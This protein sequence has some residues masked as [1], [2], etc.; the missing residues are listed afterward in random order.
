MIDEG[1]R[2][3][4][5]KKQQMFASSRCCFDVHLGS[6]SS[7]MQLLN[8]DEHEV[9]MR[10]PPCKQPYIANKLTHLAMWIPVSRWIEEMM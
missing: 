8:D 7:E 6:F 2:R 1:Q 5:L 4:F 10:Y 3:L 9:H